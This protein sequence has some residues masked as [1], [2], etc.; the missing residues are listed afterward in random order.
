MLA[1]GI[2]VNGAI[3]KLNEHAYNSLFKSGRKDI[4]PADISHALRA[5]PILETRAV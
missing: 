5:K 3:Y 4:M 2:E 1:D